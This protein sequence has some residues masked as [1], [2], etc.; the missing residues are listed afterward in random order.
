[1]EL[2]LQ[3]LNPLRRNATGVPIGRD[4]DPDVGSADGLPLNQVIASGSCGKRRGTQFSAL[5]R[6]RA[7]TRSRS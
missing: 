6:T 1:M 5:S 2:D 7:M 3:E 4:Q